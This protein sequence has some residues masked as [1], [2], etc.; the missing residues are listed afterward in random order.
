MHALNLD[1]MS[2][3]AHYAT[4][5]L[6]EVIPLRNASHADVVSYAVEI[7]MRYA[8]CFGILRCGSKISLRNNRHFVGWS[9]HDTK[10]SL[11][12]R[13]DEVQVEIQVD[14][15]DPSSCDEPGQVRD[16]ILEPTDREI[17]DAESQRKFIGIDGSLLVL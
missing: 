4:S 17:S 12:F 1:R 8:E 5:L 13:S 14:P 16:V 10:R 6:D 11:L 9:S 2:G 3:V 7:P 15:D